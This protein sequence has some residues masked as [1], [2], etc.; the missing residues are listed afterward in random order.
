MSA[1]IFPGRGGI[2]WGFPGG[3]WAKR[4]QERSKNN[5]KVIKSLENNPNHTFLKSMWAS[6]PCPVAPPA[7]PPWETHMIMWF[8][9]IG[10][11]LRTVFGSS[12]VAVVVVFVVVVVVVNADVV[13]G[14]ADD[15]TGAWTSA[16]H[17][18]IQRS[19]RN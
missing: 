5:L 8:N 19:Y 9:L 6:T 16:Q 13:G 3:E 17:E 15:G 2:F 10:I 12:L 11:N 4:P 14:G 1:G 7:P 18:R